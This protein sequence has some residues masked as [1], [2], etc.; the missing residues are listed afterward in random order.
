VKTVG[1]VLGV[2]F[3]T[4]VLAG[5]VAGAWGRTAAG[6]T[7]LI[8]PFS[9][10]PAIAA[11]GWAWLAV[12]G[13]LSDR[14]TLLTSA[15]FGGATFVL[16]VLTTLLPL[17]ALAS[18]VPP[19][20]GLITLAIPPVL[21]APVGAALA[22][23]VGRPRPGRGWGAMPVVVALLVLLVMAPTGLAYVV[24]PLLVAVVLVAPLAPDV[25]KTGAMAL[26]IA[27]A[28][29]LPFVIVAGL[30]LGTAVLG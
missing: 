15:S 2:A 24:A 4:A 14:A 25:D 3:A 10:G 5:V 28:V 22:A 16:G 21:A 20:A 13:A 7:A 8:V 19:L 12:A 29:A 11:G 6:N 17:A 27:G 30:F 26:R 18:D 9:V 23:R 1:A